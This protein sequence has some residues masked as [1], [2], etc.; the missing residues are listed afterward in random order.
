MNTK[1]GVTNLNNLKGKVGLKKVDY[2]ECVKCEPGPE[3]EEIDF[4]NSN[5]G[6]WDTFIR[7]YTIR[8]LKCKK[9][10]STSYQPTIQK[11]KNED[12]ITQ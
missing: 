4:P 10:R 7:V 3:K 6:D 2:I 5:F 1:Q 9:V 11:D 12:N 8:C